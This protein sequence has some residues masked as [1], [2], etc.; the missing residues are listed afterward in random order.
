MGSK[1]KQNVTREINLKKS[2][3]KKFFINS[4]KSLD[5]SQYLLLYELPVNSKQKC[6]PKCN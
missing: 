1:L 2:L 4:S 5:I 3:L 6:S